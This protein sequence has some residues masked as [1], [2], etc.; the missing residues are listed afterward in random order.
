MSKFISPVEWDEYKGIINDWSE[1]TFQQEVVWR[2]IVTTIDKNGEDTNRR[3]QDIIIKGLCHYNYFRSWP[4]NSQTITG[5][6]D[7]QT[8][9]LY[10]NIDYL[11][12]LNYINP[13]TLQ[14]LFNPSEDR[15]IING[16]EY[17]AMG[18]SQ[19][20]QAST[21]P[22][23]IFIVLQRQNISTPDSIYG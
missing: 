21:E 1:D 10:L 5:E 18:D 11:K 13:T 17:K 3:T 6:I 14:F 19:A 20:A 2:K 15:F 8:V 12:K 4:I 23:L 7:K 22:I 9:M 16:I